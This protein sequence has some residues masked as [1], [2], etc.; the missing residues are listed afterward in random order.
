MI[1]TGERAQL[2]RDAI[3]AAARE[4]V[5]AEGLEALSLRRLAAAL[6]VTAPALYAHLDGKRD[7]LRA[8]AE[9]EFVAL[10][11]RFA[12]IPADDP[13]ERMRAASRAYVAHARENPELFRVMFLFPPALP[14]GD[15]G[16]DELPAATRAFAD[17]V[18]FVEEAAASG[19]ISTDDVLLTALAMWSAA[20]GVATVLEMG[21]SFPAELQRS[22]VAEVIDRLLRGYGAEPGR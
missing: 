13:V 8:L 4:L 5:A 22:L 16:A 21:F 7:L 1:A 6:G 10:Q 19:A 12:A 11:A 20:H 2:T 9:S 18:A 15:G 14:S 17:S 3:V